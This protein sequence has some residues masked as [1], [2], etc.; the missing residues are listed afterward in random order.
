MASSRK[1]PP[2]EFIG[3]TTFQYSGP[4][5]DNHLWV[6]VSDPLYDENHVVVVSFTTYRP[7]KDATCLIEPG[8]HEF[9]TITTCVQYLASRDVKLGVLEEWLDSGRIVTKAP[10]KPDL[11]ARIRQGAVDSPQTPYRAKTILID[12]GL[13]NP[14]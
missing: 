4:D 7:R 5:T 12:Q 13:A 1:P 6:V 9:V 8:E 10:V 3:G 2:P 11:L 14:Y